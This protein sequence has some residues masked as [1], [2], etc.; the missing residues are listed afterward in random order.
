MRKIVIEKSDTEFYTAHSGLTL[1]GVLINRH[2]ELCRR[3]D[4]LP[5][6][7]SVSHADV[8]KSYLGLLCVGKSDF[9]AVLGVQRDDWFKAALDIRKVPSKETGASGQKGCHDDRAQDTRR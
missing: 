3:L 2:S 4:R 9:E 1:V 8:V 5:G 7:P 6:T